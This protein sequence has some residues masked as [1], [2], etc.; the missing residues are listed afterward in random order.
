[1]WYE[2]RYRAPRESRPD[3]THID[4]AFN[5]NWVFPP[6][7]L[8]RSR[9]PYA[10]LRRDR[11]SHVNH[12]L[13]AAPT[14]HLQPVIA[15]RR[16]TPFFDG[17]ARSNVRGHE[18]AVAVW[19]ED[20]LPP[21]VQMGLNGVPD[22]FDVVV[23]RFAHDG[24]RLAHGAELNDL[25]FKTK[26]AE[27]FG[28]Q[29]VVDRVV[30]GAGDYHYDGSLPGVIAR[31]AGRGRRWLLLTEVNVVRGHVANVVDRLDSDFVDRMRTQGW[32]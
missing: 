1:M 21:G 17:A 10:L 7:E 2:G 11:R 6:H 9:K 22:D 14:T 5:E 4:E 25:D 30:P 32:K 12:C 3:K 23:V 13:D 20:H 16:I 15:A 27:T 28:K 8:T 26:L 31:G 24:F 19:Y 18:P 29:I